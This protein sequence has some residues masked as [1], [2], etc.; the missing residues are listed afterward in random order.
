MLYWNALIPM[1]KHETA[2]N[3]HSGTKQRNY[4]SFAWKHRSNGCKCFKVNLIKCN[5]LKIIFEI[6]FLNMKKSEWLIP[7][8]THKQVLYP[9]I[10]KS[11]TDGFEKTSCPLKDWDKIR[12]NY[13]A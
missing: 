4:S 10:S 8:K 3:K 12:H 1:N 9:P 7:E 5:C 13:G 6:Y 11:E 2:K